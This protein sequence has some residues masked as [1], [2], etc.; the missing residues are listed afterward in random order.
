MKTKSALELLKERMKKK[1]LKP[2][3]HALEE[4]IPIRKARL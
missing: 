2:V 3:D 1:E 4:Y